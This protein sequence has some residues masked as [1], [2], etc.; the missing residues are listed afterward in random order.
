MHFFPRKRLPK[1]ELRLIAEGKY[2]FPSTRTSVSDT[3]SENNREDDFSG[4]DD[5]F[6][7]F[8]DE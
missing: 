4:S 8:Y 3:S 2:L 6:L 1:F 5:D 7:S